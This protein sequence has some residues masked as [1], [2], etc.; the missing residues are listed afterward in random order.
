MT[1]ELLTAILAERVMGWKVGPNR[2]LTGKRSWMSRSQFK[3]LVDLKDAFQ[4]LD[5][6]TNDYSLLSGPDRV[7]TALVRLG[8]RVG[9]GIGEPK[10]RAISLAVASASGIAT[11][12]N[13]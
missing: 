2:F 6:A 11:E 4:L 3:P 1:D 10:A 5:A 9:R 7:F 13:D 8:G 12:V